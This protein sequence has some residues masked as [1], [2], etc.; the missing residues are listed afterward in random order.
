MA[1]TNQWS[2]SLTKLGQ[3]ELSLSPLLTHLN[4]VV[5][6]RG[7]QPRQTATLP[8]VREI[9]RGGDPARLPVPSGAIGGG[10]ERG[11]DLIM[12]GIFGYVGESADLGRGITAALKTLEY[13]GYDSWGIAVGYGDRIVVEKDIGRINGT[14]PSLPPS[15]IGFGH[16][17]WA[18]HGGVTRANAHPHLDDSG[19]IAVIHNGIIEN[20]QS[21]KSDLMQRGR[22]FQSETDS[23]VIAH[24]IAEQ[25]ALGY[26]LTSAL[27][28]TFRCLEGLNAIIAMHAGT[29]EMVAAKSGS[30]LIAGVGPQGVTIASDTLALRPHAD[31]VI[32]V[33]DHHLIR[34]GADGISLYERDSL[35]AVTPDYL[36]LDQSRHDTELGSFDHFMVKEIAEQPTVL[37][38][39]ATHG[40]ERA[41]AFATV[42]DQQRTTVMTGCGSAGYAAMTGSFLFSQVARRHVPT[43]VG[44][45]FKYQRHLLSDDSFVIAL[46]QSGETADLIE[47]MT[48][49][50]RT[51][52]RLG[53]LVN[54]EQSTLDRMVGLKF[55]LNAGPEQCVLAT[56]SYLAKVAALLMMAYAL[57]GDV[58][59]GQELVARAA[60]GIAEMLRSRLPGHIHDVAAAIA[61]NDHMFVIGRGL[62]YP[63]ALEAALKIKEASYIHAEAFAGGELKHG[64]IALVTDGTPCLVFAPADETR[65][66]IISGATELKSRGGFIIGIS[67]NPDPI[68]DAHL[69]VPDAGDAAP[70]VNAVPA[71]LLGYHLALL[72]GNNPDRPRNLAK[73]VTVK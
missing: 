65:A 44:S 56:K 41:A 24:L 53:A 63:T 46:S 19:R 27:A 55:A 58:G 6:R 64:V 70:L 5:F 8:S 16:T 26:E 12:C 23:E 51:G 14:P 40:A 67:P 2:D 66:D 61:G 7:N 62:S 48:L 32:Y 47:A 39:L 9:E 1:A 71:Q 18:T 17:R 69:P 72:R 36:P 43:T 57:K 13:R 33:E 4:V 30:P 15:G 3:C 60:G 31:R 45:E 34:L 29:G 37:A 25:V 10:T 73:S 38:H 21:I 20:Y 52:S 11:N 49:A 35:Q 50:R 54:V 28:R 68:F 22:Q 59:R 42:I